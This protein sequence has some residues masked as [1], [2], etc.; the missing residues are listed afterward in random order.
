MRVRRRMPGPSGAELKAARKAGGLSQTALSIN[1]GISRHSVNYWECRASVDPSA[2]AM[3]RMAKAEPR[4]QALLQAWCTSTR[5]LEL[6]V[7]L[8]SRLSGILKPYIPARDGFTRSSEIDAMLEA[9]ISHELF[10]MQERNAQRLARLRVVCGAKTTRKGTPCRNRS[11]PGRK[12]CKFHGGKSTG[13]KTTAGRECIAEAQRKR[14]ALWRNS[15]A[16]ARERPCS[17]NQTLDRQAREY[18]RE[19]GAAPLR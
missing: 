7:S 19:P 13:P 16:G 14:W 17:V 3:Q 10:R 6:G 4:I 11:E 1:A 5:A 18:N 8:G 12:R 9:A 15:I 2:W